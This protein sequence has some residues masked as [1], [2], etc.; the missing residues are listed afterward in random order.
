MINNLSLPQGVR[1]FPPETAEEIKRVE[2]FLLEEFA[3]WGYRRVI[4]PL[5]EYLETISIG[6]GEELEDKLLKFVDPTTGDV[7]AL[8]PDITP[9]VG[10]IVATQLKQDIKPIRLCYNERVIRFEEKGSGKEREVFQ[11]GCELMGLSSPEADAETIALCIKCLGKVGIKNLVL[12]IGHNGLLK[13]LLDKTGDARKE[14]EE[15]LRKKDRESLE[16]SIKNRKIPKTIKD[17]IL[18][19]PELYGNSDVLRRAKKYK[20]LRP[21]VNELEHVLTV[22]EEYQLNCTVNID[23]GDLRGFNYYTGISYEVL[24]PN[25]YYPLIRGGR[26]DNLIKKYGYDTAATGFA[27]DVESVLSV[28]KTHLENNQVHFVIIPKKKNLRRESIRLAEWLR[29]SGFKVILDLNA[30][31]NLKKMRIKENNL[32]NSYGIIF[33]ETAKKIKLVESRSGVSREFS[34]L[35]ELLKGGI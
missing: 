11:V 5:F 19:L 27:V 22:I 1:D 25:L 9:Q 6:L 26:Y 30:D 24:S 32:S 17:I 28:A 3:R 10:R 18:L 29:S 16:N 20:Y 7:V 4:T 31:T 13:E 15:A 2:E 21:Y 8:R 23:L 35:E 12:D 34:D 33:L 14:I